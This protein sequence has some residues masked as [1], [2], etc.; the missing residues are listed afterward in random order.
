MALHRYVPYIL[1]RATHPRL[2]IYLELMTPYRLTA[3]EVAATDP[4]HLAQLPWDGAGHVI[5]E[6]REIRPV[7][8]GTFGKITLR[9]VG[10]HSYYFYL[11]L[12]TDDVDDPYWTRGRRGGAEITERAPNPDTIRSRL[13][14]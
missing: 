11:I 3:E 5:L 9:L 2:A 4:L 1:G 12:A 13:P 8:G 7:E 6:P 10:L 14:T